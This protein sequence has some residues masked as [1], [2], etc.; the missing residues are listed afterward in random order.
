[1]ETK[2]EVTVAKRIQATRKELFEAWLSVDAL[3]KFMRPMPGV[4]IPSATIDAVEGG[5]FTLLMQAGDNEF[6]IQGEY[7]TIKR[8]EELAFTWNSHNSPAISLVTIYFKKL[9][10]EETEVILNHTGFETEEQEK[11]HLGGWTGIIEALSALY[12]AENR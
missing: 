6:P 4:V 9:S 10:E 2:R 8:Y 3:K 11:S 12:A 7:K 5:E 1:M